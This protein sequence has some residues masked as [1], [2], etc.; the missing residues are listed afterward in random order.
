MEQAAAKRVP[1]AEMDGLKKQRGEL[2]KE[3]NA[4][5]GAANIYNPDM[6]VEKL[7][8]LLIESIE[9]EGP[10]QKEWPPA[11]HKALLFAGDDRQDDAYVREIFTRFL[12]RAYRRPVTGKEIEAIV[13]VVKEAQTTGKLSFPEAMRT[14]LAA[15]AVRPGFLFLARAGRRSVRNPGRSPITNGRRGC[16]TSSGA[17][18]RTRS[19]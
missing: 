2:E 16:R 10:I 5:T 4:W 1:Q 17:R 12:P 14:G 13:A 15:R 11:S 9:V 7:P 3:L 6:D 19:C 18:C 8:R